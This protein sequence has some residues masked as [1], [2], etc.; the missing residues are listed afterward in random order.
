MLKAFLNDI[1]PEKIVRIEYDPNEINRYSSRDKNVIMDVFA[2]TEDGRRVV[3][4][5]QKK[6]KEGFRKRM[7]YYGACRIREQLEIGDSY[8]LLNPVYVICIMDY[9]E[10]HKV[11]VP[12]G[13]I[14]FHYRLIEEH[15][16]ELYGNCLSIIF[17]EL[18]RL[19]EK[20][21]AQMNRQE[22]WFAIW[23]NCSK[24]EEE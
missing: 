11:K 16:G 4:E 3:I 15:L 9:C 18:P 19:M 2:H 21:F 14:L 5:M 23:R 20:S 7:L 24:F 12:E 8:E 13:K 10:S 1:L 6:D 17:C 22:Q